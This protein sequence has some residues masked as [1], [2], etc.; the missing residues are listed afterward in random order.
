MLRKNLSEQ[1]LNKQS[2]KISLTK[3]L[4]SDFFLQL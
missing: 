1:S 3:K 2:A 4:P